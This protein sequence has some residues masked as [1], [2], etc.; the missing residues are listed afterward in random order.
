M[1]KFQAIIGIVVVIVMVWIIVSTLNG[2]SNDLDDLY[3]TIQMAKD[4]L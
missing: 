1:Q 4:L 2:D 3:Y